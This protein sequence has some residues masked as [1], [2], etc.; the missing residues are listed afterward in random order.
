MQESHF[1]HELYL[2]IIWNDLSLTDQ[3]TSSVYV[4]KTLDLRC[5]R[6]I[7]V[8]TWHMAFTVSLKHYSTRCIW[9]GHLIPREMPSMTDQ[10]SKP[11]TAVEASGVAKKKYLDQS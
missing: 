3:T 4:C 10:P 8:P 5:L 6:V 9:Y 2:E 11:T 7:D 1:L